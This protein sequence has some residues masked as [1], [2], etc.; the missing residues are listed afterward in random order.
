MTADARSVPRLQAEALAGVLE[1]GSGTQ[2]VGHDDAH[3]AD[4]LEC[5]FG[6]HDGEGIVAWN[7]KKPAFVRTPAF[8]SRPPRGGAHAQVNQ[9]AAALPGWQLF[10]SVPTRRDQGL[11][12]VAPV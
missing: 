8:G 6:A 7:G 3:A 9:K 12:A 11:R 10:R 5:D 2:R 4:D 1:V